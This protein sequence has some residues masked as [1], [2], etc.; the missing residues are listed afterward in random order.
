MSCALAVDTNAY[1][2]HKIHLSPVIRKILRRVNDA[3]PLFCGTKF[4]DRDPKA[5]DMFS[6][7]DDSV[8]YIE[9]ISGIKS[10]CASEDS[11]AYHIIINGPICPSTREPIIAFYRGRNRATRSIF[12]YKTL[13]MPYAFISSDEDYNLLKVNLEEELVLEEVQFDLTS[14]IFFEAQFGI[15]Q[16]RSFSYVYLRE[17]YG[18]A[19]NQDNADNGLIAAIFA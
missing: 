14:T 15:P 3:R 10:D 5:P 11:W 8:L 6:G 13:K 9:T 18:L 2:T 7:E 16:E 19:L 4:I 17:A 1:F 12:D